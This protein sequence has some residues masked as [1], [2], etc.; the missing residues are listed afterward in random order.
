VKELSVTRVVET[1]G[2]CPAPTAK[3]SHTPGPWHAV[4]DADGDC[5]I[6]DK[7]DELLAVTVGDPDIPLEEDEANADLMAAAPEMLEALEAAL[8]EL[9]EINLVRPRP[10]RGPELTIAAEN[11]VRAAIQKAKGL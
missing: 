3:P 4:Y 8:D 10:P 9:H 7:Q 11:K 2:E 6:F 5:A 1:S